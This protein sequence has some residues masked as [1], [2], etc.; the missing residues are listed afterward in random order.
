ME[1]RARVRHQPRTLTRQQ[2]IEPDA[3]IRIALDSLIKLVQESGLAA[4]GSSQPRPL[5]HR[6][7]E[8]LALLATGL[9]DKQIA[10]MLGLSQHTVRSHVDRLF[11]TY[12]VHSR[13]AAVTA[14]LQHTDV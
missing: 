3:G 4:G 14:W 5:S 7:A 8:V 11:R 9:P 12:G 13:A 6:Q 2:R 1:Q 10:L